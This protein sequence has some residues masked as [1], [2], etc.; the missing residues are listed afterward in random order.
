M[1]DR[2]LIDQRDRRR[3]R[4][5]RAVFCQSI[6][7]RYLSGHFCYLYLTGRDWRASRSRGRP[8]PTFQK[9]YGTVGC[10]WTVNGWRCGDRPR[11]WQWAHY[12]PKSDIGRWPVVGTPSDVAYSAAAPVTAVPA[13]CRPEVVCDARP[14]RAALSRSRCLG[15]RPQASQGPP[16]RVRRRAS[17]R[18]QSPSRPGSLISSVRVASAGQFL[19]TRLADL[20]SVW[21][22]P[23][24]R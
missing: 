8:P 2:S 5:R 23:P 18:F 16:L 19:E 20:V 9:R 7:W 13:R 4:R 6:A 11:L 17:R 10:K 22:H 24:D 15:D 3:R 1:R 12:C 14:A 21:R